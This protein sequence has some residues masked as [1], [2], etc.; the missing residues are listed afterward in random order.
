MELVRRP[1]PHTP[2]DRIAQVTALLWDLRYL[3]YHAVV[4][5]GMAD[6]TPEGCRYHQVPFNSSLLKATLTPR[7][8]LARSLHLMH[9]H[10][11]LS[12]VPLGVRRMRHTACRD[13]MPKQL[14]SGGEHGTL[15]L[16]PT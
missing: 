2:M 13:V 14:K 11:L 8:T 10:S 4:A 9:P 16:T 6:R 7:R 15:V 3:L 5:F 1:Q 12:A